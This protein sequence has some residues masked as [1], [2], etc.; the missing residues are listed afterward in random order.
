MRD[1]QAIA[2]PSIGDMRDRIMEVARTLYVLRGHDGFSFGDI[3][4][5]I[6]TTRANIHHHY[7]NKQRLMDRLIDGFVA[8]AEDRIARHWTAGEATFSERLKRQV[9]DLRQFYERFNKAP[10]DRNV[11]SPLSRIRLDLPALGEPAV[12]ALE[13]LNRV[14]DAAL[15]H[16]VSAAIKTGEL[17]PRTPA[18]DVV[19]LLR[20]A[21]LSC[22]P[23]TLDAGDFHEVA[24]LFGS[25]ERMIASAWGSASPN[26][27]VDRNNRAR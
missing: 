24:E 2:G 13:R 14:Y 10:G 17:S 9:D 23:M 22:G 8:D 27:P 15:H 3:A 12:A 26:M 20:V 7:G 16:A 18:A 6:G 19:R 5:A 21:L 1:G 4:E 11:W 25:I